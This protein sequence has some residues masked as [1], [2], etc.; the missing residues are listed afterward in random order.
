MVSDST[1]VGIF[2]SNYTSGG[3]VLVIGTPTD[4]TNLASMFTSITTSFATD[5]LLPPPSVI[6]PLNR[7]IDEKS[8]VLQVGPNYEDLDGYATLAR[9]QGGGAVGLAYG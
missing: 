4:L 5:V 8:A 2:Q 3:L 9:A 1:R 7:N 6:L